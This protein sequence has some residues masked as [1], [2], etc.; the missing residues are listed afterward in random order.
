MHQ[1]YNSEVCERVPLPLPKK[2]PQ[3]IRASFFSVKFTP[4]PPKW[5]MPVLNG[6]LFKK[7]ASLTLSHVLLML[8]RLKIDYKT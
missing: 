2:V 3:T 4:L 6:T 5:V 8:L 1:I 7:G